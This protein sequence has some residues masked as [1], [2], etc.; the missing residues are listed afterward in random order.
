[1]MQKIVK[2]INF[3]L[4]FVIASSNLVTLCS[5]NKGRSAEVHF[6]VEPCDAHEC[7]RNQDTHRCDSEVCEHKFCND[8]T[9]LDEFRIPQLGRF[10]FAAFVS[11]VSFSKIFLVKSFQAEN[12]PITSPQ[13][14]FSSITPLTTVL[15]I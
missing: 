6:A 4:I 9:V 5:E 14:L 2:T 10:T 3:I 8:K 7:Q 13:R 1:M 12:I 11:E 15:R